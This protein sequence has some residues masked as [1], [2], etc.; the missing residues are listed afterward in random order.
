MTVLRRRDVIT[1]NLKT[2]K[3]LGLQIPAKVL[4]LLDQRGREPDPLYVYAALR[5][6]PCLP[7]V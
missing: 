4:F 5:A 6:R 2:A 3:A 1:L 7:V